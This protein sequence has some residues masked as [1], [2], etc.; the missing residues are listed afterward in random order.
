MTGGTL[1][2][3][4]LTIAVLPILSRLY[5]P[6]DFGILSIILAISSIIAPAVALKFDTVVLLPKSKRNTRAI[7]TAALLA[8]LTISLVWAL[9][10]EFIALAF[11]TD[12]GP[13]YLSLWVFG[14][15]LLTGLFSLFSQLAL[16]ERRYG[17][18]ASRTVLQ[19]ITSAVSQVTFGFFSWGQTGLLSGTLLGRAAGI[20]KLIAI[21]KTYLGRH[22]LHD[23]TQQVRYYWRFPIV[24][25]PS[26]VLNSLGAQLPLIT[27]TALYGVEFAGEL[28]MAERITSV[29]VVLVGTAIGQMFVAELAK[30]KREGSRDFLK[31]FLQ[32]SGLLV[33]LS[34]LGFGTLALSAH[35]VVPWFLGY[36]WDSTAQLV[37]ILAV[38]GGI[39]L[40][41]IPLARAISVFQRA[42]ANIAIDITRVVLMTT[43]IY[44]AFEYSNSV[45]ISVW[46]IYG[47]LALVYLITWLYV[48][49]LVRQESK[50]AAL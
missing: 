26:G 48:L 17:Q 16:R 29:P 37:Q 30:M 14:L 33:G 23:I 2:A 11:F 28:G 18:V 49:F 15:T 9:F 44:L 7:V 40:L 24:F 19:S 38:T 13:P 50:A 35:W 31:F 46:L 43:A 47:S 41:A 27:L 32:L 12:N 36:E 45:A 21:G 39:Q 5:T 8:T 1:F 25:A 22:R 42:R 20:A 4:L 6:S 10:S 3:Q 34:V